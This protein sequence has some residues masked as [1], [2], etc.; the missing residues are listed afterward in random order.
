[1]VCGTAPGSGASTLCSSAAV[2]VC[3]ASNNVACSCAGGSR[4]WASCW[5][6]VVVSSAFF[7]SLLLFWL[8][9][10]RFT[11]SDASL[12]SRIPI[13]NPRAI[14]GSF[15]PPNNNS[16]T[17][18]IS[19][20]SD[21]LK[22]ANTPLCIPFIII[23]KYNAFYPNK[24]VIF[25]FR[26]YPRFR[27]NCLSALI[28]RELYGGLPRCS[29]VGSCTDQLLGGQFLALAYTYRF[30][31]GISRKICAVT[32]NY[33]IGAIDVFHRLHLSVKDNPNRRIFVGFDLDTAALRCY[34]IYFISAHMHGDH[35]V[36]NRPW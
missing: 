8:L 22:N 7:S 15:S 29:L 24:C 35:A 25:L 21:P 3:S 23:Y 16:A 31:V 32:Y 27:I 14:S 9:F 33:Q 30:Q 26:F 6:F 2:S 12:K 28:Q 18:M 5:A 11:P 1:M 34:P 20:R 13:P 10:S 36:G 4:A 19:I 17:N